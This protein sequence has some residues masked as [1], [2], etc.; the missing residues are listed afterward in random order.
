MTPEQKMTALFAA[1]TVPARDY[2]FQAEVVARIAR[3][4][5]WASV[6]SLVPWLIA[7]TAGLWGLQPV[8]GAAADQVGP[9]LVPVAMTLTLVGGSLMAALWLTRRLGRA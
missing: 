1:E 7:V 5:A 3:H 4:R 6:L 9:V 8:I 2:A